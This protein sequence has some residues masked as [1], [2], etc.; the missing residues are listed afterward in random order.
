MSKLILKHSFIKVRDAGTVI[1]GEDMHTLLNFCLVLGY[2]TKKAV[3]RG[4][5]T[6]CSGVISVSVRWC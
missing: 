5:A 4:R 3:T 1:C 2:Q 6:A